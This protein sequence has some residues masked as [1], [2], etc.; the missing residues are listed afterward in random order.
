MPEKPKRPEK[1]NNVK[2]ARRAKRPENAK[3]PRKLGMAK[4]PKTVKTH[5]RLNI[6]KKF[7][8]CPK[9]HICQRHQNTKNNA[10]ETKPAM[11]LEKK[12]KKTK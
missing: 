3:K 2:K 1:G 12:A 6:Y 11:K 8:K 5:R 10:E 9:S 4:K 7:Q